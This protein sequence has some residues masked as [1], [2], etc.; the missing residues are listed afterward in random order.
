MHSL[1][2]L[3]LIFVLVGI[4]C[5]LVGLFAAVKL[6]YASGLTLVIIGAVLFM[7]WL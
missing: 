7:G 4:V 6:M 3:G 1:T 2:K 5:G